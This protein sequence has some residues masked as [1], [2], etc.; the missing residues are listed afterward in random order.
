MP[1]RAQKAAAGQANPTVGD[2]EKDRVNSATFLPDEAS[3][4]STNGATETIGGR[5]KKRRRTDSSQIEDSPPSLKRLQSKKLPQHNLDA[6]LG[7]ATGQAQEPS[8]DGAN[9]LVDGTQFGPASTGE[10]PSVPQEAPTGVM[11]A[12]NHNSPDFNTVIASIINH[13]ESADNHYTTQ[14]YQD[15]PANDAVQILEKIASSPYHEILAIATKIDTDP[16]QAYAT[17]KSLF[18]QTKKIYSVQEPFLNPHELGLV[19]SDQIGIIRKANMATFVSSVFGS[20]DVGFYHL[21]ENFLETFIAD[22]NRLLKRQAQLFLELKTQAYISAVQNTDRSKEAILEDLFP[23]NLEEILFRRRTAAKQLAPSES[24]FIQRARNR[25]RALL[26]EATDPAAIQKLPDKYLWEAFLKDVSEYVSK[27]IEAIAGIPARKP[28]H[29]LRPSFSNPHEEKEQIQQSRRQSRIPQHE[30]SQPNQAGEQANIDSSRLGPSQ[31]M[32]AAFPHTASI[33]NTQND[34]AEKAAQ[35]AQF[36]MQDFNNPSAPGLSQQSPFAAQHSVG[37]NVSRVSQEN[38]KP[39]AV[40]IQYHFEHPLHPNVPA[41][42]LPY[43]QNGSYQNPGQSDHQWNGSDPSSSQLHPSFGTQNG[44]PYPTQTAPTQVLYERAR[45]AATAKASP[46]NRRAGHPSQRRPW[47]TEEETSLM[48][49]LDRVQ[50]PHWSQILAMFGPGGT[51][52]EILKD[53]N[54]VQLKDKARNLKLFFLKSGI[55]VPYY[56]QCVTGE[57]KTRA[58]SR[59]A[60]N[61]AKEKA[62]TDEDRAHIEGLMALASRTTREA[63]QA[64]ASSGSQPQSM[65][66]NGHVPTA[67]MGIGSRTTGSKQVEVPIDPQVTGEA[68][69]RIEASAS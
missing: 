31:L 38:P 9:V 53:R 54:Q 10:G 59:A 17:L 45:M 28:N 46:N 58:P 48:A 33:A 42:P 57:L 4:T 62:A 14:N 41:P 3:R 30:S 34:I 20:Q 64:A 18:D 65:G 43:Y 56:L 6:T 52:N 29:L 67:D 39:D 60:K 44:I 37:D 27:N 61:E 66:P 24:E 19:G 26:E 50:G 63:D 22:G 8:T 5:L 68:P 7:R 51:I 12:D 23:Q 11:Q 25:R 47:S 36:A 1:T 55:E 21:N 35:A 69:T 13:G 16:G 32:Q 2:V 15:F 40:E 49:G